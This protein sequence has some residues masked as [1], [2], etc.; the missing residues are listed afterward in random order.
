MKIFYAITLLSFFTLRLT[1]ECLGDKEALY[2][3]WPTP[4]PAFARGMGYHAFLEKTGPDKKFSSGAY[5]CVRNNGNKFHEGVDLSPISNMASGKASDSIFAAMPGVVA[6]IN[7]APSASAYGKYIVVEHFN[8]QPALYSLYGHLESVNQGISVGSKVQA[9]QKIGKMGNTASFRIPLDRSH[10]HFEIGLRLG[11]RFQSWYDRQGFKTKNLH[12][13][14]N[15]YNLVGLDPLLFYAAFKRS[16]KNFPQAYIDSLIPV[17]KIRVPS[18]SPPQILSI[19]PCLAN[20]FDKSL[21]YESWTCTFGKYGIP[22][23]FEPSQV[24]CIKPEILYYDQNEDQEACR[25]VLVKRGK[26]LF[27][28]DILNT[29]LEI[30]FVE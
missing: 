21:N 15:G 17:A 22:L 12:G 13:N 3:S 16:S 4:N 6:Y 14:F 30:L 25:P 23:S 28:S 18:K 9:S 19:N 1:H 5:G 10:L 11:G 20:N 26:D 29:Y 2:L 8:T 24:T 7:H 27:L